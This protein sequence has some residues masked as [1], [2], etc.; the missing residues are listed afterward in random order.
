MN[1]VGFI[2]SHLKVKGR[3]P[4]WATAISAFVIIIA[5]SIASGYRRAISDAVSQTV[6]DVTL[7]DTSAVRLT[8]ELRERVLAVKGVQ[9]LSPV[10]IEAGV[11]RGKEELDGVIFKGVESADSSLYV[12]IPTGLSKRL[13][14]AE[15]DDFLAYFIGNKVRI[16]KFRVLEVYTPAVELDEVMVVYVPIDDMRRVDGLASDEASLLEVRLSGDFHS[17]EAMSQKAGELSYLTSL[18]AQSSGER[19]AN[20]FDW[21]SLV[22][23]NVLAVLLLMSLVAAFNMVS[24]FL[25][26]VLRSA[27][28]IG[29]LKSLGMSN[30]K[31]AAVFL[32]LS[33]K[34]L[35]FG[36]GLGNVAALL[37]CLIQGT[38]HL[39]KL[40]PA[41][42]F[43][44]YVP[45]SVN[46]WYILLADLFAYLVVMLLLLIPARQISKLDPAQSIKSE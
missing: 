18:M 6:S 3:F 12:R 31:I 35:L 44:S 34:S 39:F 36:L 26:L 41:N 4:L 28:T 40:N 14:I 33:S 29:T 22:D 16:R 45:V 21:L 19:Y 1:S 46:V 27:S 23:A 37:F 8:P 11:A 13:G 43:V 42:Y 9:S 17:R 5:V 15:G 24:G 38:T 7:Y 32:R 2:A 25:A 30:R 10:V 20:V